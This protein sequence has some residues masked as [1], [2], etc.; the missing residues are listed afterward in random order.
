MMTKLWGKLHRTECCMHKNK[1]SLIPIIGKGLSYLFGTATESDLNTI[2][3]S[4]SRSA[5]SQEEIAH[6][7][8]ENI[9]VLNITRVEMSEN[10]QDLNKII[11][12]LVKLDVKL[13]NITQ[14]L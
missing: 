5:K 1:R 10:R 11:S 9:L 7:V 13:G 4:I 14:V 8:G 12:S 6:A 2:H 3:S